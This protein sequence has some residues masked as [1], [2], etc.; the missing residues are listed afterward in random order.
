MPL[1]LLSGADIDLQDRV[2]LQDGSDTWDGANGFLQLQDTLIHWWPLIS[3]FEKT[4]NQALLRRSPGAQTGEREKLA[5][6]RIVLQ[7]LIDL[8]LVGAHLRGRR[9]LLRNENSPDETAVSRRQQSKRQ[10]GE[11][12]PQPKNA[13]EK[14]RHCQPGAIQKF[15][16]EPAVSCDDTLDEVSGV[17]LHPCAFMSGSAFTQNARTHQGGKRQ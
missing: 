16:Q 8:L 17:S 2:W 6:V 7:L 14:D 1:R 11:K 4:K 9:P 13:C 15:V 5:D 3:G 12:E 10:M